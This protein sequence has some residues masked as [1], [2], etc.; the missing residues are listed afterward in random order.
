VGEKNADT[1]SDACN[2]ENKGK[3]KVSNGRGFREGG[4]GSYD[5]FLAVGKKRSSGT[6]QGPREKNRALKRLGRVGNQGG[7]SLGLTR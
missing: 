2:M 4:F 6:P 7:E 5:K 1:G 3:K